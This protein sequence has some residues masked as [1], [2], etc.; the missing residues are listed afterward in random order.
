VKYVSPPNPIQFLEVREKLCQSQQRKT[1]KNFYSLRFLGIFRE[2]VFQI[3]KSSFVQIKNFKEQR[4]WEDDKKSQ[5]KKFETKIIC[6]C[7]SKA[8]IKNYFSPT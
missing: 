8:I 6:F 2:K 4:R 7:Q 3:K 1:K 5:K